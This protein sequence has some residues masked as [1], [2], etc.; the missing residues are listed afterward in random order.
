MNATAWLRVRLRAHNRHAIGLALLALASAVLIWNLV[1]FFFVFLLLGFLAATR[2]DIG[3]LT[4]EWIPHLAFVLLVLLLLWGVRDQFRHRY[5]G[6]SDRPIIGWHVFADFLLLPVRL[7]FAIWGN[8]SAFR[9]LSD[10]ELFRAWELL[11]AVRGNGKGHLNSLT[12]IEPDTD[13]LYR[14]ITTLQMLDLIDLHRGEGDWFYTVRST[15]Q[16]EVGKLLT[17]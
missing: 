13:K 16:E 1:Y 12:L 9:R 7:T 14:L 10:A 4:P 8:I 11:S 17:S 5:E 3:P 15:R 2:G 6:V